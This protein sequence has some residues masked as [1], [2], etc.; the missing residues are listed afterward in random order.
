MKKL[1]TL[2]GILVIGCGALPAAVSARS[3]IQRA[4]YT[5]LLRGPRMEEWAALGVGLLLMLL[6]VLI[7]ARVRWA[8]HLLAVGVALLVLAFDYFA[9]VE[10]GTRVDSKTLMYLGTA[11]VAVTGFGGSSI[12]LLYSAAYRLDSGYTSFKL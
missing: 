2:V 11:A 7:W 6:G 5:H 4:S 10:I 1:P 8:K 9:L 3:L 12:L